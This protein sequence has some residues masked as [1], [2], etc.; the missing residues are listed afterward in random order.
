MR[1]TDLIRWQTDKMSAQLSPT[2]AYRS[3]LKTR[4]G[5]R[6]VKSQ[7]LS[8]KCHLML[9][10]PTKANCP[11]QYKDGRVLPHFGEPHRVV[12]SKA[13]VRW[14]NQTVVGIQK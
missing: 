8:S 12:L 13:W 10:E 7:L 6:S 3:K 5:T 9:E 1:G 14:N 11:H 2:L 4:M